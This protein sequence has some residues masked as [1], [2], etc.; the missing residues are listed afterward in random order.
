MRP[1][2][3]LWLV[4]LSLLMAFQASY[5]G[6]HLARK[7]G[8]ARGMRRRILISMSALSIALAIWTMHFVG[9]LAVNLPVPIDFLVLP[10]LL[11]FLICVLVVGGAVFAMGTGVP[12][13]H[14]IGLGAVLMGAGIVSMHYMG[15]YA[16]HSSIN[17]A[18]RPALVVASIVVGVAASGL[19]L[20]LAFVG[21]TWRSTVM[22]AVIMALAISAMHYTAMAGFQIVSLCEPDKA[23]AAP[24][25]SQSLLAIIVA[26]VAFVVSGFFLLTLV[27]EGGLSASAMPMAPAPQQSDAARE[28]SSK[29]QAVAVPADPVSSLHRILPVEKNGR[30]SNMPIWRVFAVQAQAHYTLLFDGETT[31]FCPLSISEVESLLDSSTFARVHRSHIINLDRFTFVRRSNGEGVFEASSAV[32]YK[33]PVA[34]ARRSWLKQQLQHRVSVAK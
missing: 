8:M 6:L 7:I 30:R 2:H 26:V 33:V 27:P 13:L 32:P 12:T 29:S 34:R 25:L 9:M 28:V 14:R 23:G 1:T 31:W 3:E 10:T 18:H 24:V 17:M 15:M 22:S 4:L 5:V 19:S 20:W 21:A 11:S 16:L